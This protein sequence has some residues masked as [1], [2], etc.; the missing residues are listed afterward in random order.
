[1][2]LGSPT[3]LH[4]LLWFRTVQFG[5]SCVAFA[6]IA[7]GSK[8]K[9]RTMFISSTERVEMRLYYGGPTY[10]FVL[11]VTFAST[12]YCFYWMVVLAH[13][14]RF[15][16]TSH[17]Q[18][19][20]LWTR[21]NNFCWIMDVLLTILSL[22]AGCALAA[23]D[24]IRYCDAISDAINCSALTTCAVMCVALFT[25]LLSYVAW[26]MWQRHQQTNLRS[27]VRRDCL[28]THRPSNST[29]LD[30]SLIPDFV[31]VPICKD[32]ELSLDG[33]STLYVKREDNTVTCA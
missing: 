2:V 20:S 10:N 3:I 26:L 29:V 11:L 18:H 12:C 13:S 27:Y 28:T 8:G 9:S 25:S 16:I 5:L 6:C 23:S 30:T 21:P 32:D 4:I 1:M 14:R 24:Y 19:A 7:A 22:S 15:D 33:S 17:T 31:S